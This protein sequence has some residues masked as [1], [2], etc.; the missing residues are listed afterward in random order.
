VN[1]TRAGGT[2]GGGASRTVSSGLSARTVP[3]PTPTASLPARS[4][5]TSRRA[6]LAV[7]Q[8]GPRPASAIAPSIDSASF[9]LTHG[10]SDVTAWKNGAFSSRA[11]ATS[12]SN[13]TSIPAARNRSAPPD[14]GA[15]G[16]RVAATTRETPAAMSASTHGGV[17]PK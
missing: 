15:V 13:A 3:S 7:S 6:F 14:A 11:A 5:W 1:T 4:R 12:I 10:R 2:R 17:L 9:T 8:A 16:S